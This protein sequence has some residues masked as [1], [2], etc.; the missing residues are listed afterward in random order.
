[1]TSL[2]AMLPYLVAIAMGMTV[3]ILVTGVYSMGAEGKDH[4][5]DANLLM[6]WRIVLQGIAIALLALFAALVAV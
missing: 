1:M 3:V 6:R 4:P 2:T 5:H